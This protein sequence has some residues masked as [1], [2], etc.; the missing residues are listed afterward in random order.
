MF[1]DTIGKGQVETKDRLRA[2]TKTRSQNRTK[3]DPS[4][5]IALKKLII[6]GAFIFGVL[7]FRADMVR[8]DEL[9]PSVY[10]LV[11]T[12]GSMLQTVDGT[13][14]TYGDGS[15]EHPHY[16]P[17][18]ESRMHM[19]KNAINTIVNAYGEV[20]WGMARF[21]QMSGHN[22][23]CMCS[24]ET[25]DNVVQCGPEGGLWAPED[26][27]RL[28]DVM[29]DYPDYD[30]PGVHDRVCI[31]YAGGLFVGCTDPISDIPLLGA[32]ILVPI[33]ANT[34][35]WILSWVDHSETDP[36]DPDYDTNLDP[37][38]QVD[39]ELRAVGGTPLGGALFDIYN[40]LSWEIGS[41]DRRGCRPYS[42][43]LL[44]DGA[45]ECG[46]DPI[47]AADA[48]L[49]TPDLQNTCTTTEDCP[50]NSVCS[51]GHCRYE[52]KTHVIAFA[53]EPNQ[54]MDCHQISLAGNTAGA[55]SAES[56]AEIV[57]AMAGIIASSIV[58]ELCNGIDDDCDGETDEDFSDLG[59]LCDN[60]LMG[61]CY[62]SGTMICT[63][64]GSGTECSY[65][66]PSETNPCGTATE[67]SCNSLDDDC[68]GFVDNVDPDLYPEGCDPPPDL[69]DPDNPENQGLDDP[70][71]GQV[72][73]TDVGEC[74][75]G[76]TICVQG[77][78][79][80]DGEVSPEPEQCDGLDNNCNGLTDEGLARQCYVTRDGFPEGCV[81]DMGTDTWSCVGACRTGIQVCND[82]SW[83]D[84]QGYVSE[85]DEVCNNV[86]DNC[87]GDVDENLSQTC[88]E[89]NP[90]GTCTGNETCVGGS[91]EGCDAATP[92]EEVCD[93][94][95]NNCDGIT[96]MISEECYVGEEGC[97]YDEGTQTWSCVGECR[98]GSRLCVDGGF[99]EC[100]N[101]KGPTAEMCNGLDDNCDGMTD[102]DE[103]GDPLVDTCYTGPP[104]TEGVG[105]CKAGV[106]TCTNG[107]WGGCAGEVTPTAEMCDGLD[108]N[109]NGD[110][111]E[112]LGQTTCGLGECEKTVDNCVNGVPQDCDPMEGAS[113]EMCDGLDN[114]CDG[115][116]DGLIEIC[117]TQ[118]TGCGYDADT[119]T[120]SCEGVCTTGIKRCPTPAQGGTGTWGVCEYQQGPVD[121]VCDGRD[122]NCNGLTDEDEN[123]DP[124][125]QA[126]Y[127]PGSGPDTGCIYD[128][129]N[130]LWTCE[131][132][133]EAGERL[134]IT[135]A[136][137][138]CSGQVTPQGEVCN[139]LDDNCDGQTDEAE[140]MPALGQPCGSAVGRCTQGTLQCIDGQ[141]V[142]E[143]GE[144]PFEGECNGMDDNC[145]G[146]IDDPDEVAHLEG[147]PCGNT[148]GECEPGESKCVG[149][150][151]VCVGGKQPTE[152][153]CNGLD[154][155][156]DGEIDN[157]AVCPPNSYC[158]DGAC[159]PVCDPG[160]EFGCPPNT[161]CTN[162]YIDEEEIYLCLPTVGECG[163][164]TCPEGW[165]CVD[166]E[167]V[168]PCEG[169]ECES[170]EVCQ[171]G[172][173]MDTSCTAAGIDCPAGQFCSNHE[174]VD[175]PCLGADCDPQS[176][177]CVRDCNESEC[178]YE[179]ESICMC[180]PGE[181]CTQD[182]ECVEDLC[183]EV[184]CTSGNV[185]NPETGECET[186]E[187]FDVTC[188]I[189]KKCF[190]GE[191]IDDPCA[192][193][194]CPPFNECH[195]MDD[196]ESG[197]KGQCRPDP[198]YWDP[199][200]GTTEIIATGKGGCGCRVTGGK[201]PASKG[202]LTF[203]LLLLLIVGLRRR[204]AVRQVLGGMG[205]RRNI[206]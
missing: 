100:G 93:G 146:V 29:A 168:D 68:D 27:C 151:I 11:D 201:G 189:G 73:G 17:M 138:P 53:V 163:G 119:D 91:W 31:N 170:W 12:S 200:T 70:R 76:I 46:T 137:E 84:C 45:E 108:N 144:G 50:L 75:T 30:L 113:P 86:D 191:C 59:D 96:D 35:D 49:M 69:C 40:Q 159:R 133:C 106:R 103:N 132:I 156:C 1:D 8:A 155:D 154:D 43:I 21:E 6:F 57:S 148:V 7:V 158:Y 28:C 130:D 180:P 184:S 192:E 52:V 79:V 85:K 157:G 23:L 203:L 161:D 116:T 196:G 41:D 20:N 107:V 135:G 51:G 81:Y 165:I 95:D 143:G 87:D 97:T 55:I 98:I 94:V 167:C 171:Q 83:G 13:E 16:D 10:I 14:N 62:C 129:V 177:Y 149:G 101:F 54:F 64:D 169:V 89:T 26:E 65:D 136:W 152:E 147:E 36:G 92:E 25:D 182:A 205:G 48:L 162:V 185:C 112:G 117:Y 193:V 88:Q 37:E 120:W 134:C 141:E 128:E 61:Q 4:Q 71:V 34:E 179:C 126:C 173:C 125:S 178:T 24:D 90:W 38:D 80:C 58:M 82:A 140:N 44:T 172:V 127:P 15:L 164:E 104:G 5:Y 186:D 118:G 2:D 195:L 102:K 150:E 183:S 74:E 139:N 63:A 47:A 105:E 202:P 72:C 78:I 77:E 115:V 188:A 109:C 198:S 197:V 145:D 67:E 114:N 111:D 124:L 142:C 19:A 199:G 160:D 166:E 206:K 123:G 187:C 18:L 3:F 181:R 121:E 204:E 99:G 110:T 194:V 175:D 122:N 66:P 42:V 39:P 131:G 190:E 56:E 33:G 176:E 153:S 60:G 32:D 22:Y 174:C 9:N